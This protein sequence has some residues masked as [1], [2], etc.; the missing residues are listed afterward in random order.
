MTI[1]TDH[2]FATPPGDRDPLRRLRGHLP[3]PVSI[4][5][6]GEGRGR[7]GLTVSSFVVGAGEPGVVIGLVDEESDF[8]D[9]QPEVFAVNIA[10]N[11]HTFLSEAFAGT[12]PAPG[13]PFTLGTWE[14]TAWGPVLGDAAGWLG[15]RRTNEPRPAGW[16]LL[17]EATVEHV[18]VTDRAVLRHERGRYHAG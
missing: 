5:T 10:S 6:T 8:W 15:V 9:E 12:A 3:A 18:S 16:G 14:Q 17:V 1:H 13:G 2:P 11:D 7:V 4:W